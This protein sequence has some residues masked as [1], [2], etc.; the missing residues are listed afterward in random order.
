M[1]LQACEI[2]E[3]Q[4]RF[5]SGFHAINGHGERISTGT[6]PSSLRPGSGTHK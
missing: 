6:L 5:M 1:L 2:D 3:F 4:R